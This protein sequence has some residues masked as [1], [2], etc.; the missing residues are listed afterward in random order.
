MQHLRLARRQ[1]AKLRELLLVLAQEL[2]ERPFDLPLQSSLLLVPLGHL[3][4]PAVFAREHLR[5]AERA[6]LASSAAMLERTV[7]YAGLQL[8]EDQVVQGLENVAAIHLRLARPL[9]H[10]FQAADAHGQ[11]LG[12]SLLQFDPLSPDGLD[13][14][15]VTLVLSCDVQLDLVQ[16]LKPT[17]VLFVEPAF[18]DFVD[19]AVPVLQLLLE[20]GCFEGHRPANNLRDLGLEVAVAWSLLRSAVVASGR[21]RCCSRQLICLLL[22]RTRRWS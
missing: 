21:A 3:H 6:G 19:F 9:H 5:L 11:G 10:V 7:Q 20:D 22:S 17:S 1:Q 15:D 2:V 4:L 8:T 18:N 12:R 14:D 16:V 13:L